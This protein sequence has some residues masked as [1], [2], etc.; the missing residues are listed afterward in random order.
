MC[1]LLL[2][3][4]NLSSLAFFKVTQDEHSCSPGGSPS[5][6]HPTVLQEKGH[7][8]GMGLLGTGVPHVPPTTGSRAGAPGHSA[9]C[10]THS[11]QALVGGRKGC[12]IPDPGMR[13]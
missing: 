2:C 12:R 1:A 13:T 6:E 10:A 9:P 3:H 5:V 8:M 7:S 11:P 4:S